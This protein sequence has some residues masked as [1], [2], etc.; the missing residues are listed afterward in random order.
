[1]KTDGIGLKYKKGHITYSLASLNIHT[2]KTRQIA[3]CTQCL[4]S[5]PHITLS[6]D[7]QLHF[8]LNSFMLCVENDDFI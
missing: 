7:I 6:N 3:F 5:L 1:M 4:R 2:T 8:L